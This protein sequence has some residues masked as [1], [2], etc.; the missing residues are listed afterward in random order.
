M[1]YGGCIAQVE[2]GTPLDDPKWVAL[3][4]MRADY[5]AKTTGMEDERLSLVFK[6]RASMREASGMEA[7][8]ASL[9]IES[10]RIL[11]ACGGGDVSNTALPFLNEQMCDVQHELRTAEEEM[12]GLLRN[13]DRIHG[14]WA[15]LCASRR[16]A[17]KKA[18]KCVRGCAFRCC[19]AGS[20]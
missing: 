10:S 2:P 17:E 3:R 8:L 13:I 11:E 16:A 20:L 1:E 4:E 9:G 15:H 7:E 19:I 5:V 18:G 14:Q 6:W 12:K